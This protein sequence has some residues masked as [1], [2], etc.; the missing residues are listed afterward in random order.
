[1]L[2]MQARLTPRSED[3]AAKVI[4]GEAIIINLADGS[5]YSMDAVGAI[6]WELIERGATLGQVVSSVSSAYEVEEA[7]ARKDIE[8][9]CA[10]LLEEDLVSEH[11]G[12]EPVEAP[13]PVRSNGDSS[14]VAPKL[15]K[16]TDMADLLALDPPVPGL[17]ENPWVETSDGP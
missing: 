16:Y 1:M 5:Y 6:V 15:L 3:V 2:T 8:A 13:A 7:V 12:A 17:A 9:L 4:D 10:E 11:D 14:Y